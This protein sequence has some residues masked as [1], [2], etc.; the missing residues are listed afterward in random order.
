[1]PKVLEVLDTTAAFKNEPEDENGERLPLGS[2]KVRTAGGGG[3]KNFKDE[4]AVPLG[5][6]KRIPLVGE[7]VITMRGP[8]WGAGQGENPERAY[9]MM[10]CNVQDNLNIGILPQTFL[11]GRNNPVGRLG[12]FINSLGNPQREDPE[13]PFIGQTFQETDTVK[14]VQPYEGD[15]ILESRFGQVI[16]MSSTVTNSPHPDAT[17]GIDLYEIKACADWEG[18]TMQS[19]PIMI[20]TNGLA[21]VGGPATYTKESFEDDKA[22]ICM[23]SGQ[24]LK[25]FET[26]QSNL[27]QGVD[28]ANKSEVSQVIIS[29]DRLV[30]NAK[31]EHVILSAKESVQIATP[32]WAADMNEVLSIMDEFLQAMQKITSGQSQYPT[33]VG[34]PTLANPEAGTIQ[35]LVQRMAQLKQ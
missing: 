19:S 1:M 11:R 20:I 21:P 9:Y 6:V 25:R 22:T 2:V 35:A 23:T 14:P 10:S 13:D 30:F 7:H 24:K 31:E 28:Q 4:W 18:G 15:T 17:E 29:S 3:K 12:D 33:P 8:S 16:R 34:G 32:D 27:G 26:A 5:P